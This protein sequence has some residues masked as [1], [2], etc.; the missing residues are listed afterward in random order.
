MI[1]IHLD[2]FGGNPASLMNWEVTATGVTVRLMPPLSTA[3]REATTPRIE[4]R[5]RAPFVIECDV[6]HRAVKDCI[7]EGS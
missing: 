5:T 7:C 4:R 1:T 6:C 2:G 3:I